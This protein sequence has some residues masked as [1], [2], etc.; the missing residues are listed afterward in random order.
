MVRLSRRIPADLGPNRL[1]CARA[2]LGTIPFDLT[3]SNPTACDLP[4]PADLLD[5]L[6]D[7][8]GLI[9]RPHPRGPLEARKAV[10]AEYLRWGVDVDPKRV[11]L[12]ASTS[13][14]YGLLFRLLADPGDAVLVPTPSYPLFDHLTRL[15]SVRSMLYDLR[16]EDGWRMDFSTI[17]GGGDRVRA[18]VVVHPNNPTNSFV[19]PEDGCRLIRICR[20]RGWAL[21]S[22]EVFLPYPLDGGPG[23]DATFAATTG[24]LTFTLGGLSKSIGLPQAKLAWVV[25]GGPGDKVTEV[26]EGLDYATDA[27]LTVST[28]VALAAPRLLAEGAAVRAAIGERCRTNLAA[29]RTAAAAHPA[30]EILPCGGGWSAVLALC[31]RLLTEHG[32][33]VHPGLFFGFASGV[34]LVLSLLPLEEIFA[35]GVRRLFNSLTP[36]PALPGS[37]SVD[38]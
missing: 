5:A 31:L 21:I 9:Y 36:G 20:E 12:T 13:E 18:V 15:E 10:A 28:P 33:A 2:A 1:A 37:R 38:G 11:V 22:D 23:E 30:T 16:L 8:R 17:E 25:A 4:Y 19:H 6:A 29:L 14:A 24:C 34:H 26:L 32:V 27:Y 35:E 7:T 3:E